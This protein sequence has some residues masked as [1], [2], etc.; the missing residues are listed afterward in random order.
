MNKILLYSAFIV[1]LTACLKK[2]E[3]KLYPYNVLI[4]GTGLNIDGSALKDEVKEDTVMAENDR[5]G[6]DKGLR[7]FI[8]NKLTSNRFK[9]KMG[10]TYTYQIIDS[11]GND[12]DVT[13]SDKV[14]D[15]LKN[16]Y[17]KLNKKYIGLFN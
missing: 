3:T 8:A 10:S 5:V 9:G 15:S 2:K 17:Y 12:L 16:D 13:L 4:K 14:K 7:V 11:L 1:L 6:Y